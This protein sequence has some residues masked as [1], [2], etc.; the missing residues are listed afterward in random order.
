MEG[1]IDLL[2]RG[3]GH[4]PP[5]GPQGQQPFGAFEAVYTGTGEPVPGLTA[6]TVGETILGAPRE[7]FERSAFVGQGGTAIDGA[8]ALEA[9]IAAL[10]SSGEEGRVLLPG[11]AGAAGLAQ[12]PPA[13]QDRRDP[14]AGGGA[15]GGGGRSG[16]AGQ[17]LPPVPRRPSGSWTS[18]SGSTSCCWPSG[19]PTWPGPWAA[20]RKRWE[21]GQA[22]LAEAQARVDRLQAERD[23]FGTL[24]DTDTLQRAQAQVNQLNA[25]QISRKQAES[26]LEEARQGEAEAWTAAQDPLFSGLTPEQAWQQASDDAGTA[27]RKGHTAGLLGGGIAA[28][29][30]AAAALAL[31]FAGVFPRPLDGGRRLRR[32]GGGGSG[33][34]AGRRRRQAADGGPPAGAAGAL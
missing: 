31:G 20:R 5:P 10:A 27:E 3:G 9:R 14:P 34:A 24:P 25:L 28:L 11:G 12:P 8:P 13:Q 4:H 22:A 16:P 26:Q 21:E 19:R 15:G 18:S 30:L 32:A 23:R 7:V 2:W 29:A 17:G 1:A 33:P 6:D